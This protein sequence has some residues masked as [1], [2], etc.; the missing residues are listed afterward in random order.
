MKSVKPGM[1]EYE[2]EAMLEAY[3]RKHGA[4]GS[5]YTSII[6]SG[7]NAT[8]LHY[9][10]NQDELK[11]GDLLLVDAGA[12]YKGYAS[13]ITRTFPIN[14]KFTQAQRDIYDLVLKT[15]KSCVD[16][17]RPGV[18]LEDLKTHSIEL[19]TEGMV[20][21][22]LL[23][24]D[25]KKLIEEKKYMQFYMH[26]LGHYLGIDVHDAGRYY[27]DGESRP[28]EAGMVM[29]IEPGLYISPTPAAFR[30]ASTKRFQKNI[31]ASACVS[32]T[33]CW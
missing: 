20:E 17:V 2:V 21:L 18:R 24:G 8:V 29:T 3:F 5:S 11:D 15:Q 28:A 32:K 31:W 12:E 19:L 27:F 23:N 16:M 26:N 9:I 25:P 13:D 4:S 6:G 33:T 10:S 1:K 22:G 14:G 7:G 30:K